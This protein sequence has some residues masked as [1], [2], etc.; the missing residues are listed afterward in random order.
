MEV[1]LSVGEDNRVQGWGSTRENEQEILIEVDEYNHEF[2]SNPFIFVYA[3]GVLTKDEAYQQEL[4]NRP[5]PKTEVEILG[6]QVVQLKLEIAKL[7]G[8]LL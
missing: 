1:Y 4:A 3:D 7:K 5:K 8:G 2:F 6:E